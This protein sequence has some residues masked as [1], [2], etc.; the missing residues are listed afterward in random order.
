MFT[1]IA[2]VLGPINIIINVIQLT[3]LG[4]KAIESEQGQKAVKKTVKVS[5]GIGRAGAEAAGSAYRQA[6]KTAAN[7][8]KKPDA[9]AKKDEPKEKESE[10]ECPDSIGDA[11]Y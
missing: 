3:L 2:K 6:K 8:G 9:A 5:K 11:D 1:R 10:R 7:I 4:K